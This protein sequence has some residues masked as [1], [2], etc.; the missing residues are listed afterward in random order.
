MHVHR[1]GGVLSAQPPLGKVDFPTNP[2]L[3][4]LHYLA[5]FMLPIQCSE[6]CVPSERGCTLPLT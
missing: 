6:E 2:L 3:T 1:G 4:L 5:L